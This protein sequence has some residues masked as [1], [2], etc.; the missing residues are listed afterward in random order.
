MAPRRLP[1]DAP[2]ILVVDDDNR[3]RQLLARYLL[4]QSLRVTAAADAG[5][6]RQKLKVIE[7]DA[8]V[9]DVMMPGEDGLSLTVS[10]RKT[11]DVPILLLT[12][13][14]DSTD[15]IAG[16][17]AGADDYLTKPFEPRELLLRLANLIKRRG[18]PDSLLD[19]ESV[20]FGRFVYDL[21]R[22]ELT[23]NGVSVR[24]TDR[25]RQL[26][27]LL[28]RA[29]SGTVS[30]DALID[31]QGS[32]GERTIDVQMN[33]LRRKIEDDPANP[34][35]LQTVRGVGYRLRFE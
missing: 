14:A 16:L 9:L 1:D 30:R 23:D 26:L 4:S 17:E 7:F 34:V 3:I 18:T 10:L 32:V 12:A 28:G 21:K 35:Y 15:R 11:R 33:R 19:R 2:H 22:E 24:L 5:E 8:I 27:S 25:E 31:N 29:P 20:R 6:A 13:R